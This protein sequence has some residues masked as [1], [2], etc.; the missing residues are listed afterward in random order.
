M[1]NVRLALITAIRRVNPKLTIVDVHTEH[2]I[3][4]VH[5]IHC[6]VNKFQPQHSQ[7]MQRINL[8]T[9][10]K[11]RYCS[12]W[13][14]N[15]STFLDQGCYEWMAEQL[16]PHSPK[17]VLDIGC[18][19]GE[20]ILAL[21]AAGV[22]T[23][24]AF[25]ENFDCIKETEEKLISR[26][27]AVNVV[28]RIGYDEGADGRHDL[29]I[30]QDSSIEETATI[31]LVHADI[32][33]HQVDVPLAAFL[34]STEPFDAVTIWLMG[35]YDMRRTCRALDPL[36]LVDHKDYR[37]RVQN[38]AYEIADEVLE[39]GGVFQA[40]DR[41]LMPDTEN[42]RSM[43][44]KMHEEQASV[45]SLKVS[46]FAYRSYTEPTERGVSMT[47]LVT[48][49]PSLVDDGRRAMHSMISFKQ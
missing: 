6:S 31:T 26:G 35:T 40:V 34:K 46:D 12:H 3:V 43:A 5:P 1:I 21:L 32:L 44:F 25:E 36:N 33:L 22:E 48:E 2:P 45:T 42:L 18:G 20:G 7:Q 24:V 30:D 29:I 47:G 14:N 49:N 13:Q 23:I 11:T 41:G 15:A 19:T 37:L 27:H 8:H 10:E 39:A 9:D 4:D 28:P 17:R 38:L 16:T